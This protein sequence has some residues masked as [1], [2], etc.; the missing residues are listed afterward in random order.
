LDPGAIRERFG[1]YFERFPKV[2]VEVN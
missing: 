2:R 1:F